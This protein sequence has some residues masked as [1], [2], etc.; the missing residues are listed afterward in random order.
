LRDRAISP[1]QKADLQD[2]DAI[3][4][5]FGSGLFSYAPQAA[6]ASEDDPE[7]GWTF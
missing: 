6:A 1:V 2:G 5:K 7:G 4:N 3:A